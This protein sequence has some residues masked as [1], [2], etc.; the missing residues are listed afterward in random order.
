MAWRDAGWYVLPTDN[1]GYTDRNGEYVCT[2]KRPGSLVGKRWYLY[3]TRDI[4][5]IYEWWGQFYPWAGIAL[6][7]GRSGAVVFDADVPD[8]GVIDLDGRPDLAAALRGA[9]GRMPTRTTGDRGH[10]PYQLRRNAEGGLAELFGDTAGA[11][12]IY[13]EVRCEHAVVIAATTPHPDADTKDGCYRT[14]P[15]PV[16]DLP[17]VL[18]DCLGWNGRTDATAPL[19]D[20]DLA[21]FI[22]AHDGCGNT[23][24]LTWVLQDFH[25]RADRGWSRHKA[26]V[27]AMSWAFEE[28]VAGYYPAAKALRLLTEA[29]NERFGP[30]AGRR[31]STP[32]NGEVLELAKWAASQA[33]QVDLARRIARTR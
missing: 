20:A 25:A 2:I 22:K 7:C 15:G 5:Q 19:T 4:E 23:A 30:K 28:A 3:S 24:K 18:R 31:R 13:G 12:G 10:Y 8:L 9:Q 1:Y 14:E 29:F 26:L 11:F 32:D 21:A 17:D 33:M 27:C 16:A 6:D